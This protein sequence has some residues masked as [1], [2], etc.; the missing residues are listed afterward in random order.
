[1]VILILFPTFC[2]ANHTRGSICFIPLVENTQLDCC[3]LLSSSAADNKLNCTP[4]GLASEVNN[5]TS[6][7]NLP[8]GV[9]IIGL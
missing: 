6:L 7:V 2:Y 9:N 8:P 4:T 1:M 5:T 3:R